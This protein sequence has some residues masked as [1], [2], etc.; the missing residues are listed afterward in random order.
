MIAF[1][2][3]NHT[4]T[5]SSLLQSG[6]PGDAICHVRVDK[7]SL[8]STIYLLGDQ[9]RVQLKFRTVEVDGEP[10]LRDCV[11]ERWRVRDVGMVIVWPFSYCTLFMIMRSIAD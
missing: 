10:V 7:Q 1:E 5:S 4:L 9:Q 2:H 6:E 11:V 8:V 3:L